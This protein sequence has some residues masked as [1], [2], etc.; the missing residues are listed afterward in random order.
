M[1][2][3]EQQRYRELI[4][5]TVWFNAVNCMHVLDRSTPTMDMK[6]HDTLI[7]MHYPVSWLF[8]SLIVTQRNLSKTDECS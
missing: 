7:Q 3:D 8:L 2:L 1:Y 4:E 5:L 6:L